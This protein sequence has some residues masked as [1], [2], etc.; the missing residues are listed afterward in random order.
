MRRHRVRLAV[1]AAVG[2]SL[3]ATQ[4]VAEKA[5][6]VPISNSTIELVLAV[7]GHPAT[8]VK[9]LEGGLIRFGDKTA[10]HGLVPV[11]RDG[12]AAVEVAF[13]DIVVVDQD[14]EAIKLVEKARVARDGVATFTAAAIEARVKS[15]TVAPPDLPA[16]VANKDDCC[17]FCPD[18]WFVCACAVLNEGG[19]CC[20]APCCRKWQCGPAEP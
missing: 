12:G 19:C 8:T 2:L 1:V 16:P 14:N 20:D 5:Y 11:L 3:A 7:P 10:M 9:S 13:F 4:G 18:G 15:I 17:V 6:T